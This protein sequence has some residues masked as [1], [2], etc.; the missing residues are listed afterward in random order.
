MEKPERLRI[1]FE[2]L[3]EAP[4]ADDCESALALMATTLNG[5]EDEY[6]GIEYNAGS[7]QDDR[8]LY[9]PDLAFEQQSGIEGVRMF[10]QRGHKTF[11]APNGAIRIEL[12]KPDPATK[13][14]L[15]RP[16]ADGKRCPR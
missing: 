7:L 15:D 9:P 2:R 3:S 14:V 12:N 13:V 16:G 11:I 1:F 6:S 10:R 8:R 5:V 4:L